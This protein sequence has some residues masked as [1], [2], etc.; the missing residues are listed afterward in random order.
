MVG[1]QTADR[2]QRWRSGSAPLVCIMRP[3]RAAA[4]PV[5]SVSGPPV[6]YDACIRSCKPHDSH[7]AHIPTSGDACSSY[8]HALARSSAWRVSVGT[9]R[10]CE[11]LNATPVQLTYLF[12]VTTSAQ[13]DDAFAALIVSSI[14]SPSGVRPRGLERPRREWRSARGGGSSPRD[15]ASSAVADTRNGR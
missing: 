5:P 15:L 8:V 10:R 12:K 4:V 6:R 9:R 11:P 3:S 1:R 13:G 7:R 2:G 14:P